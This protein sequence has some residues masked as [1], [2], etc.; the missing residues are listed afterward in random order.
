MSPDIA[1]GE[2]KDTKGSS[3]G[4]SC[5]ES[6]RSHIEKNC[7]IT[8]LE[9]ERILA[10]P[11]AELHP[12]IT[13]GKE[14][15]VGELPD[16]PGTLLGL[17]STCGLH[18]ALVSHAAVA[19]IVGRK[20]LSILHSCCSKGNS[21]LGSPPWAVAVVALP[22]S[23]IACATRHVAKMATASP[24]IQLEV[25]KSKVATP[26]LPRKYLK[27]VFS[28]PA[29]LWLAAGFKS[30]PG[31]KFSKEKTKRCQ[32]VCYPI[33]TTLSNQKKK[34]PSDLLPESRHFR[35]SPLK[36]QQALQDNT[37]SH[38][39][40]GLANACYLCLSVCK[41]RSSLLLSGAGVGI[42]HRFS[43]L[44]SEAAV[45]P[46]PL[47]SPSVVLRPCAS[48]PGWLLAKSH[49]A[50][51]RSIPHAAS[52]SCQWGQSGQPSLGLGK[53]A[54]EATALQLKE[55]TSREKI[56]TLESMNRQVKAVEYAV[57]GPIVLEAGEIEKELWKGIKKPFTEVIKAN[58]GDSW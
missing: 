19:P 39:S 57:R 49:V 16:F 21:R 42:M 31:P 22:V 18:A 6:E 14:F 11:I 27:C 54:T 33:R 29:S 51:S 46:F 55:K 5:S 58:T 4:G 10:V 37:A 50:N 24:E 2:T 25:A 23:W 47:T 26:D 30:K 41:R 7:I 12:K 40:H 17:F 52:P 34:A 56:L 44:S 38:F 20:A 8:P 32:F 15:P 36:Q 28:N 53:A 13:W 45:T 9:W 35:P 1:E 43:G 3:R 48:S